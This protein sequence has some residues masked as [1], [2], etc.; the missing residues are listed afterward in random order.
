MSLRLLGTCRELHA[1]SL[2]S[3]LTNHNAAHSFGNLTRSSVFG[4]CCIAGAPPRSGSAPRPFVKEA[5]ML[6]RGYMSRSSRR[7]YSGCTEYDTAHTRSQQGVHATSTQHARTICV[8]I[9]THGVV[10]TRSR[11]WSSFPNDAP[12]ALSPQS[13]GGR[14]DFLSRGTLPRIAIIVVSLIIIISVCA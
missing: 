2:L 4:T 3:T 1:A 14:W 7:S 6:A 11:L 9:Q 10:G 12:R 8:Y 13:A 5:C